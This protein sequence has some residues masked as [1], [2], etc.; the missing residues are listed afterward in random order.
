MKV[1]LLEV[2]LLVVICSSTYGVEKKCGNIS[3]GNSSGSYQ[4][5]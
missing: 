1:I 2:L 3:R 4:I 5:D